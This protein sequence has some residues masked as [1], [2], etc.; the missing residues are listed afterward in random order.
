MPFYREKCNAGR[1]RD[2]EFYYTYRAN[3][4]GGICKA[5]GKRE[6]P[7]KEAQRVVN[8]R[9][10]C[11]VLTR[12]LN[13]NFSGNDYYI[14]FTYRPADR[15]EGPEE[16]RKQIRNLLDRLRKI[17]N[18]AGT[19]LKYIWSAEVGKRGAAHIH[20]VINEIDI[21][22]VRN[23]WSCGFIDV[24]PLDA[25]GQYRKL[26]EY[27][28][29]YSEDTEKNTGAMVGNRYNPSKNLKRPEPKRKIIT[30][31]KKIPEA[32][33][34]PK[35]WYLD[36]E[37]E[38]RGIHEFTGYAYLSYTLIKIDPSSRRGG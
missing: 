13:T 10:R 3:E 12:L 16:L 2:F 14:T 37:S 25:S 8:W 33:S 30:T 32:I 26:A 38:R 22:K 6:K 7:T 29:K 17:Q 28:I 11:K 19:E 9:K 36:K 15:P 18:R 21:Q 4:S 20:M 27:L 24:K 23:T 1:T 5:R 31:R 35:G 34:V